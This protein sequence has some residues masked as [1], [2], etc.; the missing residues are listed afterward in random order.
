MSA[1]WNRWLY[2]QVVRNQI[3]EL[4]L[5]FPTEQNGLALLISLCLHLWQGLIVESG[6]RVL[7]LPPV[8]DL[9]QRRHRRRRLRLRLSLLGPL[10]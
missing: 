9:R 7:P 2:G 3:E 6:S 5:K 10:A 4:K 8:R 1:I